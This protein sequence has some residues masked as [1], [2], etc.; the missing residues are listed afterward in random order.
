MFDVEKIFFVIRKSTKAYLKDPLVQG[1][2]NTLAGNCKNM[3]K[4]RAT[5][6][7][8]KI[9]PILKKLYIFTTFSRVTNTKK[10]YKTKKSENNIK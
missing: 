6:I 2:I 4:K 3:T 7:V 5:S 10:N 1:A 8:T 9:Q